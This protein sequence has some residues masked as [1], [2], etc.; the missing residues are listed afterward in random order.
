MTMTINSDSKIHQEP[1]SPT[2]HTPTRV[3]RLGKQGK[4]ATRHLAEAKK[5]GWLG[6]ALQRGQVGIAL[7]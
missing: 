2:C 4:P 1:A 7:L 3:V 5:N 6:A